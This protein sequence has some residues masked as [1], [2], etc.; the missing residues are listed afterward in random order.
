MLGL[1]VYLR[2]RKENGDIYIHF[3]KSCLLC[4]EMGRFNKQKES[5]GTCDSPRPHIWKYEQIQ[6]AICDYLEN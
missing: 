1:N 2:V 4:T 5:R 6:K 3:T